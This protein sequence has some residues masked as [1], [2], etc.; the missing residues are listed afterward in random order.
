MENQKSNSSLKAIIIVL[1]ILLVGSLAYMYKMSTDSEKTE[2][3]LVTEKEGLLNDLKAAKANYDAA[4]AEN[5]GLSEELVA[6][7]AKI[8][9]LIAEVEKSKGDVKSLQHFKDDYRR[10]KRDMDKLIAENNK[11]KQE[12]GTLTTQRDST[13]TAL[14]ETKRYNDTLMSQNENLSRTVEKAAKVQVL[15]LKAESFKEK[16]SG[17][18]VATEKAKRVDVLKVSFTLA[19]NEVAKTG[20]KMYYIQVIDS[21]NNVVGEKKTE[22]FGD[23]TLTYSFITNAIYEGKTMEVAE[24]IAGKDF[25]KGLYTVNVFDK[26]QLVGNKTFTLK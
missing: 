3:K 14:G 13:M 8:E 7:R 18:L 20:N 17:K 2:K 21:K 12:N 10:L 24:T 22:V 16:S 26:D 4:I 5:T 11:L 6:E 1:S 15:N 9:S 25:A 19:A 23:Y